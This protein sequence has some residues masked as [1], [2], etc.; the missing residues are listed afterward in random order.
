[1]K[2]LA[3]V[4]ARCGSQ[5]FPLKSLA[6][7]HGRPMLAHVLERAEEI[8]QVDLV[9]LAV[10]QKD[11]P[12]LGHL[13]PHVY[14]GE[15]LDVLAR[16]SEAAEEYGADVVVRLTGDCPLLAPDIIDDAL[17][18]FKQYMP[19]GGYLAVCQPY[20]RVAD[21]W[22]AEIF[23]IDLLRR[24]HMSATKA[25]QEHVTTWMRSNVLVAAWPVDR[26]YR[27][28]KCSVDTPADLQVV[29]KIREQLTDP[30]D[31]RAWATWEAWNRAGRPVST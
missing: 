31:F 18:G 23:S 5:R 4:Q 2:V 17:T 16:F 8:Q 14:G 21:G 27:K 20:S 11:L 10:P 26:D 19:Q 7:I 29:L 24:A 22:D 9:V 15:E 12:R 13:W 3:I 30:Q 28:L 25:Q 6:T 1:M